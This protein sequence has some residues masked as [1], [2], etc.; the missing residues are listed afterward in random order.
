[1]LSAQLRPWPSHGAVWRWASREVSSA[2]QKSGDEVEV[3]GDTV[4]RSFQDIHRYYH[5]EYI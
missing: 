5:V 1:L 2:A 4:E 3:E